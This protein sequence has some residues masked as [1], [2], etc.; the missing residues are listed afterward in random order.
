MSNPSK[1]GFTL[2]ELLVV[3]SITSLLLSMLL[4]ALSQARESA[5]MITCASNLRQFGLATVLYSE[6]YDHFLVPGGGSG[7]SMSPTGKS[8]PW[9][10]AAAGSGL[11]AEDGGGS[12]PFG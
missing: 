5:K 9:H 8:R 4:P 6:D 1:R 11:P 7:G 3:I 10:S 2:I 12:L